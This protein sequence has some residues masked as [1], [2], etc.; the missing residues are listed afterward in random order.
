MGN[1]WGECKEELRL[2]PAR[3][4]RY[5]LLLGGAD[6]S[7]RPHP[8]RLEGDGL[9]PNSRKGNLPGRPT[10]RLAVYLADDED[11]QR[12]KWQVSV[13]EHFLPILTEDERKLIELAL[14]KG[15]PRNWVIDT[16]H[17]SRDEYYQLL[18]RALSRYAIVA[19]KTG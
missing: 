13:V 3:K 9:D 11:F 1:P 17:I 5:N 8:P 12:L 18:N 2:Y 4:Q 7:D 15:R 10:E 6:M 19:G 16:M 14:F